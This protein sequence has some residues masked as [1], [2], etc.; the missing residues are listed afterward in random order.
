MYQS[1][2]DMKFIR[3]PR[4]PEYVELYDLEKDP[5]EQHNLANETGIWKKIIERYNSQCDQRIKQLL[6]AREKR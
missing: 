2:K 5:W 4:R 1:M 6:N 3:Y